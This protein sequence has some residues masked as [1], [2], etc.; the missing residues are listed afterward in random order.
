MPCGNDQLWL[1]GDM[2][3]RGPESLK[4][5]TYII[6]NQSAIKCVLGNHDLHFLAVAHGCKSI[7]PK[8]TFNDIL[9]SDSK[10]DVIEYL[11]R[12][13]LVVLNKKTNWIMSHAGIYPAWSAE[14][15]LSL[16]KEVMQVL[17]SSEA[18]QFYQETKN[19]R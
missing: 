7:N 12:L 2:I 17:Q 9:K 11:S 6:E 15:A 18:K 5:M 8:D 3:N 13:P 1:A 16:S 14:K 10:N 4:V 19:K